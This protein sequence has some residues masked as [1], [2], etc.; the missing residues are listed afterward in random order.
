MQSIR[1]PRCRLRHRSLQSKRHPGRLLLQRHC[2]RRNRPGCSN[3]Q[4]PFTIPDS[5]VIIGRALLS[6]SSITSKVNVTCAS[7]TAAASPSLSNNREMWPSVPALAC[8][9]ASFVS[10]ADAA[11][12]VRTDGEL[13]GSGNGGAANAGIGWG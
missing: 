2:Q 13:S 5:K 1:L 11:A 4:T 9:L 7:P 8:R 12:C 10:C 3:G 6:N